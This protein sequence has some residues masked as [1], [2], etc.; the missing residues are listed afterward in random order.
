MKL[1]K[2][3]IDIDLKCESG[4]HM[5][6]NALNGLVDVIREKEY[7]LIHDAMEENSIHILEENEL[8]FSKMVE[9]GY[10]VSDDYDEEQVRGDIIS[11]LK[12]GQE[13]QCQKSK[14]AIFILTYD[15]N[16]SCPYCYEQDVASKR[17]LTREQI[18]QIF[19]IYDNE[20][21]RISFFGGEPLLPDN[22]E[23]IEYIISKAPNASYGVITNGYYLEE[24]FEL[25][26]QLNWNNIQVTL[27]GEKEI[28]DKTRIL[29]NGQETFDKIMSG[30]KLYAENKIPVRIR[31]NVHQN[32]IDSCLRLK[33]ELEK[34]AW[35]E[36]LQFEMQEVFQIGQA[37][38]KQLSELMLRDDM[39]SK[40]KNEILRTMGVISKFLY[41]GERI[42]PIIKACN[43]EGLRRFFDP[44][45]NV[46]SCILAVGDVKKRIG[47][48]EDV[49]IY[50]ANSKHRRDITTI[51]TCRT[52]KYALF[53]GGGCS[54]G[55]SE[56]LDA[57]STP[58]C[59][60][61]R[62]EI[63]ETIPYIYKMK[64]RKK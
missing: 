7:A 49:I 59:A 19:K 1:L 2:N 42:R 50:D 61:I 13:R 14:N 58:N 21:E 25:F 41:T 26:K 45:G 3:I 36:Y 57:M 35:S 31:M 44:E 18:D 64:L 24:F 47:T 9:R 56:H 27:D 53:C 15:C 52:C 12:I 38:K 55:V 8:L 4:E 33:K 28:H 11:K 32:N 29:K 16:F 34:E 10:I 37:T 39:A 46:Y 6:I 23:S 43:A 30:I 48:Y 20:I 63:E 60:G 54:N 62:Q 22:R 40:K 17:V 5:L 51:P